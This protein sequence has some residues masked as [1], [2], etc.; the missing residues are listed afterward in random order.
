MAAHNLTAIAYQH[1]LLF[2]KMI[3]KFQFTCVLGLN[4]NKKL[5]IC[6]INAISNSLSLVYISIVFPYF[7][8]IVILKQL[9]YCI[10]H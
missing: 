5:F 8:S 9:I 10:L 7:S 6:L 4:C 3:L 1:I 2:I